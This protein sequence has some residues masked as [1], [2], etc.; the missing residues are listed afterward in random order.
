MHSNPTPND[1]DLPTLD[2][3][4]L[5]QTRESMIRLVDVPPRWAIVRLVHVSGF[6][7][8]TSSM[9]ISNECFDARIISRMRCRCDPVPK[10]R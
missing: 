8:P 2:R 7:P 5:T 10:E 4:R 6:E 3:R 1:L 9:A